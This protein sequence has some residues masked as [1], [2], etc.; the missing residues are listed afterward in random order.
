MDL[1]YLGIGVLLG[2]VLGYLIALVRM[3]NSSTSDDSKY[4]LQEVH[5][6][7]LSNLQKMEGSIEDKEIEC[8]D[9]NKAL[10]AQEQIIKNQK[11]KLENQ[12]QNLLKI[13]EQL[14]LEFANTANLLLEEKSQ[15]FTLQNQ[16]N[17]DSLL[18]PL[19]E[20]LSYCRA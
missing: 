11:E 5:Q 16:E 7:A 12:E 15:K 6:T 8:I 17:L 3:K 14:R 2:L 9:L 13:Q 1:L 4:V 19:Q 20:K 10:A 18:H